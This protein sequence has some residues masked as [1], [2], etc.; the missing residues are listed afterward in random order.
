M[1]GGGGGGPSGEP[2]KLVVDMYLSPSFVE[3]LSEE[4][5][6]VRHWSTVGE[7]TAPDTQ[8][9]AWDRSN[10]S[11]VLT[12]DLDF[13]ALLA[14][15]NADGPSVVQVRTRDVSPKALG[16]TLIAVL[17]GHREALE[18]G[19]LVVVEPSGSRVRILPL[20]GR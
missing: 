15:S 6:E 10:G 5:F 18:E 13:G 16:A 17:H 8:I 4:G 20:R 1:E 7:P 2:V 14:V 9:M 12:H 19:A 11:V 3:V